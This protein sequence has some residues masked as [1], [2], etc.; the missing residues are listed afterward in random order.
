M[1]GLVETDKGLDFPHSLS[2]MEESYMRL[3]TM[4]VTSRNTERVRDFT[5]PVI[6]SLYIF[7]DVSHY[8]GQRIKLLSLKKWI[9]LYIRKNPLY[10]VIARAC[11]Y[12][13]I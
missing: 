5:D 12:I 10:S 7:V 11:G 1:W 4:I 9:H 8:S 2:S 6:A 13:P 3:L